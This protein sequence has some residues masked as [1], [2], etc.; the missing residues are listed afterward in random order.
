MNNDMRVHYTNGEFDSTRVWPLC[1]P[2]HIH[3]AMKRITSV[4]SQVNCETCLAI[5]KQLL[6]D[7][8]VSRIRS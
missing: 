5:I 8:T 2:E 7:Y 3:P 6:H 4:P 1:D